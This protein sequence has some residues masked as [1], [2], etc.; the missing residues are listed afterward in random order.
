EIGEIEGDVEVIGLRTTKIRSYFGQQ[1]V[2]PNENIDIVTNYTAANG[3]AMVE[4]NIPYEAN[5]LKVEKLIEQILQTLPTNFD[6]FIGGPEINGVQALEDSNYVLRIRA[7]T[8]P[9]AQ[10]EGARVIRKEV[11]EKL[12][13]A[14]VDFPSP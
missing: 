3:Y 14:G 7:E 12:F 8:L 9:V 10:W 5:I 1:Y 11:K 6:I 13:D 4:I 2:I